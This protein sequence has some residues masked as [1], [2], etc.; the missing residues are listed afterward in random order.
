MNEDNRKSIEDERSGTER[1][2]GVNHENWGAAELGKYIAEK[3]FPDYGELF[4]KNNIDGSIIHLVGNAELKEIGII[5]VGDRLKIEQA[6][7]SLQRATVRKDTETVLWKGKEL[8]FISCFEKNLRTCCGC[9]P[10]E[11]SL[12]YLHKTHLQLKTNEYRRCG[13]ILCCYGHS[14]SIDNVDL[15]FV[16]D[17]D[18]EGKPPSTC[19]GLCCCGATKETVI[20]RMK[21]DM[22][23]L[24]LK[25]GDG[26]ELAKRI[27]NQQKVVGQK[28]ERK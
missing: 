24:S 18:V 5:R 19:L 28:M 7:G 25:E 10:V 16:N 11:P 2:L 27:R 3:G 26:Q 1:L 21:N 22:K 9:N 14:Y 17:V 4:M 15:S 13:P 6:L 12:Y 8:L 23:F 20:L